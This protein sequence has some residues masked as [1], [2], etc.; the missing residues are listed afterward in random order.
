MKQQ[1]MGV[2]LLAIRT[3][4]LSVYLSALLNVMLKLEVQ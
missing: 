1:Q 3:A 4:F 2:A